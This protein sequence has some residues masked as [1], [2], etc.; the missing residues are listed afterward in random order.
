[1]TFAGSR[2]RPV[3]SLLAL[4]VAIGVGLWNYSPESAAD[5]LRHGQDLFQANAT[6]AFGLAQ[7]ASQPTNQTQAMDAVPV[8]P[9]ATAAYKL[10]GRLK[11]TLI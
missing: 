6:I 2:M 11:A 5:L 10:P 9:S 4:L 8:S 7:T 3:T 1:M